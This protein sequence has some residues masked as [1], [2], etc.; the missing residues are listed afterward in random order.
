MVALDSDLISL[1]VAECLPECQVLSVDVAFLMD[2]FHIDER[3]IRNT[4]IYII[5]ISSRFTKKKKELIF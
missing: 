4:K 3:N 2:V 5:I 1:D